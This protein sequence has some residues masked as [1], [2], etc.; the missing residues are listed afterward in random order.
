MRGSPSQG[1]VGAT[2]ERVSKRSGSHDLQTLSSVNGLATAAYLQMKRTREAD[3]R[4][5][6]TDEGNGSEWSPLGIVPFIS[7]TRS[8]PIL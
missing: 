7:G 3:G 2:D 4:L 6:S 1:E 5:T 8:R